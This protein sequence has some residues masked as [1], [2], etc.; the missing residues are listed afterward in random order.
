M[1]GF[2]RRASPGLE[3]EMDQERDRDRWQ[4]TVNFISS[5][6]VADPDNTLYFLHSLL[7]QEPYLYLPSGRHYGPV[8]GLVGLLRGE[9][10]A[11]ERSL[12]PRA[13]SATSFRWPLSISCWDNSLTVFTSRVCTNVVF[14]LVHPITE[15]AFERVTSSKRP[16]QLTSTKSC[17]SRSFLSFPTSASAG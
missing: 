4:S 16:R 17:P 2:C 3:S 9:V 5:I 7:P 6:A 11:D 12:L 15:P 14:S 10:W 1:E 13:T 8:E